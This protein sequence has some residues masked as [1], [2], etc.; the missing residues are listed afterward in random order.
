MNTLEFA[1][2]IPAEQIAEIFRNYFE[3]HM[4]VYDILRGVQFVSINKIETDPSR[5]SIIYSIKL[6]DSR[7]KENLERKLN[8]SSGSLNIY[9]HT[10]TPQIYMNG[11]LLCI[12]IK[13]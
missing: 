8:L 9:G 13:K 2:D 5:A 10:Y 3:Q 4:M 6:L 7:D 12:S 11:D 1:K